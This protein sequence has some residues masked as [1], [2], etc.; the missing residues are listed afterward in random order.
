M[1][2]T[3]TRPLTIDFAGHAIDLLPER[4]V[5]WPSRR[6]LL[7]ADLHF[8][9]CETFRSLGVPVPEGST[10][11]DLSRMSQLV[12]QT[13]AERLI[14]LGDLLHARQ[15][16]HADLI[17]VIANWRRDFTSLHV[18]LIRGNHD[19]SAGQTPVEFDIEACEEP[20]IDDGVEFR[21]APV[22]N[23]IRPSFA[24]HVHP[25]IY[26]QDYDRSAV[27][28][29]CF[30]QDGLSLTLPSFGTFTGGYSVTAAP[31]RRIYIASPGRV[32]A[33]PVVA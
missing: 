4:A 24:G 7:V 3:T 2:K 11:K 13:G 29:P 21:H 1:T 9:K 22:D 19:R 15:A 12:R 23:A 10:A 6:T 30:V 16:K 26:L 5:W 17:A 33:M 8:G 31:G 28:V 32:V 25:M 20:C 14:L 18:R 27:R